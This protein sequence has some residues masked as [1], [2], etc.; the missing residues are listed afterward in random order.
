MK[1]IPTLFRRNPESMNLV[2]PEINPACDWVIRG[3]GRA[4]IKLDGTCC[5]I[6]DGKLYKRRV[7]KKLHPTPPDFTSVDFDKITGKAFGWVDAVAGAQSDKYHWMAWPH[8][9]GMPSHFLADGTYEL[10]GPK[11]QGGVERAYDIHTLVKH[12]DP[13]LRIE[14]YAGPQGDSV[15]YQHIKT[16][17]REF[18]HEGIVWHHP[19]GRM[20]KI[21]AI[22]FGFPK[23]KGL[24]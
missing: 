2:L 8:V 5:M 3:E 7:V 9:P 22:D 4:Y 18:D 13:K 23:R 1:K 17:M 16:A 21:K 10:V 19:D 6:L 14:A 24:K 15:S 20:A 11:I 12:D